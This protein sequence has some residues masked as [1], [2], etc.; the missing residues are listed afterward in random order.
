MFLAEIKF[1][2]SFYFDLELSVEINKIF[3]KILN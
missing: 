3:P 1:Y 2:T